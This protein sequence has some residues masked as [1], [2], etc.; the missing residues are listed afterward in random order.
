[1]AQV[2]E[3]QAPNVQV[4]F[5][6]NPAGAMNGILDYSD[7]EVKRH[8]R[9]AT[10]SVLPSDELFDCEAENM[11][12]F[13][14]AINTHAKEYKWDDE[15]GGVLHIPEDHT[16]PNSDTAYLPQAYGRIN[17]ERIKKF[18]KS[19]LG[20]ECRAAQDSYM[21]YLC[22][23]NSLTK[24]AKNK[25]QIWKDDYIVMN[26]D[27]T[28]V[29]SGN[30]LLKV[31]I[32]ESHLDTNAT[33]QSIRNKLSSLDNHILTIGCDIGRFNAYVKGLLLSLTARGARTEDLLSNLFKGYLATSDK[34]FVEYIRRKLEK[35]EEGKD[36]RAEELMKLADNKF[37]LL[38]E[39][40]TWNAPS[41]EEEKILA[42]QV[43]INNLKKKATEKYSSRSS[44]EKSRPRRQEK[45]V[46]EEKKEEVRNRWNE[47]K[48]EWMHK[49]PKDED[50][51]KPK[52]WGGK[53]WWYCHKDTGGKCEGEY[54]RHKPNVCNGQA[55]KVGDIKKGARK[56]VNKTEG[57]GKKLKMSEALAVV[58]ESDATDS[59]GSAYDSE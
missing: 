7:R 57:E 47:P 34:N 27:G 49:K 24:N 1:M 33:T 58:I 56:S 22:L 12:S 40:G 18:E 8:Y 21:I 51:K 25:I 50:L 23:L 48:P 29:P 2:Q 3:D 39:R 10:R 4:T 59:D 16:D 46:V 52:M 26:E 38:K 15:I 13:L 5:H 32:R 41:E 55:R 54:R 9:S 43:E 35:Y 42:L 6:L 45:Q 17:L 19:Y 30:L 14:E 37:K 53:Q 44:K 31:I 20:K 28:M 36:Y 11:L